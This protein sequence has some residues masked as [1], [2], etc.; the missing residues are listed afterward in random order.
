MKKRNSVID[1]MKGIL[2][3]SVMFYHLIYRNQ[4]SVLDEIIREFIYFGLPVFMLLSGYF[5]CFSNEDVF[6]MFRCRMKQI[7]LKTCL[8]TGVLLILFGPYFMLVHGY[9]LRRWGND[10]VTT[11]LRPELV[12]KIA[13]SF[14]KTGQLF[15]NLSPVWFMW[16]LAWATIVFYLVMYFVRKRTWMMGVSAVVLMI[17]GAVF[18][19]K[20]PPQSWSIHLAPL[21]AG[22]MML[23]AIL[24]KYRGIETLC[25]IPMIPA[26]V[27]AVIGGFLHY[28]IFEKFGSD[29]L[30]LSIFRVDKDFN[31]IFTYLTVTIFILEMFLGGFVLMVFARVID[32][33]KGCN[34][35]LSWIGAH[36][37]MILLLHCLFGGITAD[38]LHTYN[39]PGPN[40][41]VVPLTT[42]VVV[43]SV[44]TF[45]VSLAACSS[46]VFVLERMKLFRRKATQS[47]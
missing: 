18:Y 27:I 37:Y 42:T 32:K 8:I 39:K 25:K 35:V 1:I 7:V 6:G 12:A 11:Y 29:W 47:E 38:I 4:G 15:N 21:Y 2:I 45:I 40:W 33:I 41:Y 14:G 28:Q 19:V 20:I 34:K 26:V 17:I 31:G 3:L 46:V 44:I 10:V 23:G 22:I 16:T 13:P 30:Y 24:G 43:K 5:Y 9:T 36:T